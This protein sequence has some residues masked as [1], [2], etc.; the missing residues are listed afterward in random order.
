MWTFTSSRRRSCPPD[1][2]AILVVHD[3][4]LREHV[5][6]WPVGSA[7]PRGLDRTPHVVAGHLAVLPRDRHDAAAV[8]SGMCCRRCRAV[9]RPGGSRRRPCLLGSPSPRRSPAGSQIGRPRLYAASP[10]RGVAHPH[11]RG[12]RRRRHLAHHGRDLGG[13]D[14]RPTTSVVSSGYSC[15]FHLLQQGPS[16]IPGG[17]ASPLRVKVGGAGIAASRRPDLGSGH[18]EEDHRLLAATSLELPS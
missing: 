11:H 18:V 1:R 9:H 10:A 8:D 14:V 12:S 15:A 5:R 4:I 3:E 2:D 6:I 7:P 16:A 13:P 17:P